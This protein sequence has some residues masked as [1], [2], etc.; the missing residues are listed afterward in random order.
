MIRS[1]N[2]M[3]WS[4]ALL[5]N[6]INLKDGNYKM[7]QKVCCFAQVPGVHPRTLVRTVSASEVQG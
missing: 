3:I 6:S 2:H 5:L 4:N 1:S 7:L